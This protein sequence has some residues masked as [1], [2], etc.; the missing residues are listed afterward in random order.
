MIGMAR[1]AKRTH[2]PAKL[3]PDTMLATLSGPVPLARALQA[4]TSPPR[5]V[6][7]GPKYTGDW[8]GLIAQ[9]LITVAADDPKRLQNVDQLVTEAQNF[10]HN[11]IKWA[12]KDIKDLRAKIV[13]LLS[14][15][16]R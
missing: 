14:L 5:G 3:T 12:P 11:H 1:K 16:R 10:L 8:P 9:W 7:P 6:K 15:V 2:K 13:D 4:A